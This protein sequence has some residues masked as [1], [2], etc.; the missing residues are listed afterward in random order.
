MQIFLVM[1][2]NA[3]SSESLHWVRQW[4]YIYFTQFTKKQAK[5]FKACWSF[6]F[7]LM[8]LNDLK[9]SMPLVRRCAFGN[10]HFRGALL[11]KSF[12][13]NSRT[14]CTTDQLT[15]WQ[16]APHRRG[17]RVFV[18]YILLRD[19]NGRLPAPSRAVN[20]TLA[21]WDLLIWIMR[22]A[23]QDLGPSWSLGNFLEDPTT[24]LCECYRDS[25]TQTFWH[26]W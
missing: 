24:N 2:Q 13:L 9:Y 4:R 12:M 10:V 17:W 20:V 21:T 6:C 16:C 19:V 5:V 15:K 7:E 14:Q 3:F 1:H 22:C 26:A 8:V 11:I 18:K 25:R 23:I